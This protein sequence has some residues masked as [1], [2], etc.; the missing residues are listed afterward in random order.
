MTRDAK[1]LVTG[2]GGF[3]GGWIVESLWL[4]GMKNVRA[5]VRRWS[6]AARI[7]RFPVEIVLCDVMD[8]NQLERAMSGVE[9]VVHCALGA[10]DVIVKGLEN[11]LLAS[12]RSGVKR[13]VHLST[14]DVYGK[15]EGDIDE[16]TPYQYTG[17]AY[18]DQKIEAEKVCWRFLEMG[19]PTVVLRPTIVYGPYCKLWI[20]KYAQRLL[21]GKWGIFKGLG[22]GTCN[23]VYVQDL[24]DAIL[25][26]LD[27]EQAVG[28]AFNINGP[29]LI[30]WNDYFC[31][32]NAALGGQ[33]LAEID[34]ARAKLSSTLIE[35]VKAVARFVLKHYGATLT[36]V[37][38]ESRVAQVL[39]KRAERRMTTT[40]GNLELAQLGR[41]SRYSISRA[42]SLLGYAPRFSVDAGIDLSAQWL[43]HESLIHLSSQN[44]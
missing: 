14:I 38:Q 29:E 8:K 44:P 21:S 19:L 36:K 34:P 33:P 22:E 37:Y 13:F 16:K 40:P 41:M 32:L 12:Q 9:A 23:L 6:T 10:G 43:K 1:I 20:V 24:V 3:I 25:L 2:A 7:G 28:K 4:R 39:M 26:S 5:G 42:Q 15:T 30:T 35:P 17:S 11:V 27:S 31:R 18:G